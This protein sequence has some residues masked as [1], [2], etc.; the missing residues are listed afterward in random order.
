MDFNRNP[1]GRNQWNLGLEKEFQIIQLLKYWHAKGTTNYQDLAGLLEKNLQVTF[2]AKTVQR[3]LKKLELRAARG[4]MASIDHKL[5]EQLVLEQ[6]EKDPAKRMGP[7]SLKAKIALEKEGLH[8]SRDFV[9]M[10]MHIHDPGAFAEREPTAKKILRSPRF[11]IG[12]NQRWSSDGHDKMAKI[13]MLIY[14]FADEATH[15]VLDTRVVPSNRVQEI[16]AYLFLCLVEFHEG[17][18]LQLTTDCGSEV[19]LMS[20]YMHHLRNVFHP[21]ID[22]QEV[23]AHVELKS[24]H[25]V[26]IESS[27]YRLR[28]DIGDNIIIRFQQGYYD[29]I[30]NPNDPDHVELARWLWSRVTQKEVDA[31]VE[32]RNSTRI[33]KQKNKNGPSGIS[34]DMAYTLY[35]KWGGKECKLPVNVEYVRL[36]KERLGGEALLAFTSEEF[37]LRA[38]DTYTQLGL[39]DVTKENAWIVFGQMLPLLFAPA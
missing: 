27:W 10:V 31:A 17:I 34:R 24:V 29:G 25:N 20:T 35:E 15:K 14:G 7:A 2:C 32:L 28:L 11:P 30:Y 18:P 13:G 38:Q 9:S 6:M 37:T 22:I 4:T 23:P 8:I 21:H 1:T 39:E 26:T 3:R 19:T 16:V 33:R 36:L 5:A 12:P